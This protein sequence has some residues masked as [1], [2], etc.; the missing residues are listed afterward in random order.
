MVEMRLGHVERDRGALCDDGVE[1]LGALAARVQAAFGADFAFPRLF[2]RERRVSRGFDLGLFR[3]GLGRRLRGALLRAREE[4][5]LGVGQFWPSRA[6]LCAEW[7]VRCAIAA[8]ES[9][10]M[11]KLPMELEASPA[12]CCL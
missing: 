6:L 11:P 8:A 3:G 2:E 5:A 10:A 9:T 12:R 4:L 1:E 7:A